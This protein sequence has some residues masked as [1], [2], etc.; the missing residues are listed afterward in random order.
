MRQD[1]VEYSDVSMLRISGA[2]NYLKIKFCLADPL[3][4]TVCTACIEFVWQDMFGAFGIGWELIECTTP[5]QALV[6]QTPPTIYCQ[7][8]IILNPAKSHMIPSPPAPKSSQEAK[9]KTKLK[10]WS[11]T[12]IGLDFGPNRM[13]VQR[14]KI[15]WIT[16]FETFFG[17]LQYD[18]I[19]TA[20]VFT[21]IHWIHIRKLLWCF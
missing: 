11:V 8:P 2:R 7:F 13:H 5:S 14:W 21:W 4:T 12:T 6:N 18:S 10:I 17:N 9:R 16:R 20:G 3:W 19:L 1:G 15:R